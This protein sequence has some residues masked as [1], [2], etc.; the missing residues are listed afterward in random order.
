MGEI[1]EYHGFDYAEPVNAMKGVVCDRSME[2]N[3]P[4]SPLESEMYP[5]LVHSN[6]KRVI[7]ID[8][9]SVNHV[10]LTPIQ[11]VRDFYLK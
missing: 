4:R 1:D 9:H 10:L 8:A 5:V 11:Q 3:G 2:L 6:S 7:G